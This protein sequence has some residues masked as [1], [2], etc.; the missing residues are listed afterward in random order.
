MTNMATLSQRFC[1]SSLC[2]PILD[3]TWPSVST[4]CW[5]TCF[6]LCPA[7]T[8]PVSHHEETPYCFYYCHVLD[9][10]FYWLLFACGLK[11]AYHICVSVSFRD[12]LYLPSQ[13]FKHKA[14]PP[15]SA[16][17]KPLTPSSLN[18]PDRINFTQFYFL[19]EVAH[20]LSLGYLRESC[21]TGGFS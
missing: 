8:Y 7:P 21:Y 14:A 15:L 4:V 19:L 10:G 6:A 17:S 18:S 20:A 3:H 12:W 13:A 9:Q 2:E 11:L 16:L 5:Y 1:M